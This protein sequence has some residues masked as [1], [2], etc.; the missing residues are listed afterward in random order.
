MISTG[1]VI[2][3][4]VIITTSGLGS[5]YGA[6]EDGSA[7]ACSAVDKRDTKMDPTLPGRPMNTN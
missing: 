7:A 5:L 1:I 4:R 6:G 2:T 3:M